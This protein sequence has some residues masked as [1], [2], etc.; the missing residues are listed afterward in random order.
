LEVAAFPV[1]EGEKTY[2]SLG[3]AD[4]TGDGYSEALIAF[5]STSLEINQMIFVDMSN[6]E[7]G[8]PLRSWGWNHLIL[9]LDPLKFTG[10]R[11][12]REAPRAITSTPGKVRL[13]F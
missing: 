11:L 2:I 6:P 8:R 1:F 5:S 3:F 10:H 7:M 4:I 12:Q 9:S 13:G